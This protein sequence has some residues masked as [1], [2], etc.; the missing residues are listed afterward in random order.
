MPESEWPGRSTEEKLLSKSF[1]PT[2][3]DDILKVHFLGGGQVEAIDGGIDP[4]T[5]DNGKY[6]AKK[7]KQQPQSQQLD[8]S[9]EQMAA[10]EFVVPAYDPRIWAQAPKQNTRLARCIRSYSRNT[11]GLG[12]AVEP[13]HESKTSKTQRDDAS[14]VSRTTNK[15]ISIFSD[16]KNNPKSKGDS[17]RNGKPGQINIFSGDEETPSEGQDSENDATGE[18][19]IFTD[20]NENEKQ[21]DRDHDGIPDVVED[22]NED[23]DSER[24][25]EK[26]EIEWQAEILRELF[27]NPNDSMPLTELFYLAK[28]DEETTGNGYIEVV[29]NNVG[30]IVELHHV[31]ATTI[32]RR[33]IRAG[34]RSRG[35]VD[36]GTG[37]NSTPRQV[38]GFIQIRGNQ[39]RYFKEF[40]DRR[41]MNTQSGAWHTDEGPLGWS[42]RATEIIHFRNYDPTSQYY[43][44]PRYVPSATAIAGNR[45]AAIRNV[46]FFENDAVPRM[47]LLVS[48]GRLTS[49]SMQQIEDFV[50][51]KQRG[52]DQ[53]HR[54][55]IVQVEPTRV[56]FQQNNKT[57]IELKPLTVGVT[58]DA[59]FQ[60]YRNAN[61]EEV[62]EIFGLAPVFFSTENVNKASAAVSREITNEQEF[63]PDRLSKEYT[64]NQNIV[65]DLLCHEIRERHGIKAP[66]DEFEEREQR[67]KMRKHIL[68]Q[69]RFARM[70][71]TDPLDTAR[72]DHVYA[73]LGAMTPNELRERIDLPPYPEE[74]FFGDKPLPISMAEMSAG[75]ALLTELDEDQMPPTDLPGGMPGPGE[76]EGGGGSDK[77]QGN[78]QSP[79]I[80]PPKMP[81]MAGE[82]SVDVSGADPGSKPFAEG[83][84]VIAAPPEEKKGPQQRSTSLETRESGRGKAYPRRPRVAERGFLIA[85]N[86]MEEARRRAMKQIDGLFNLG[87]RDD[88]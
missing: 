10:G 66:E 80:D 37:P 53:A 27:N 13:L 17:R 7:K 76:E 22:R 15:A 26:K 50:R 58:E 1:D 40:G 56:G 35:S 83:I 77:P 21:P 42:S 9:F 11:V 82:P 33:M 73:S 52:A 88:N 61:D 51:G 38:Y 68:V 34:S 8:E 36:L 63:E 46:A 84:Q 5:Q 45:Q 12:W 32:R 81:G 28:V 31:P 60:T 20:P 72:M 23:G 24:E 49:E 65:T 69:F 62:R 19:N 64:I 79:D 55:M 29:R 43:G 67:R 71:L 25:R 30:R 14:T 47:A 41:V 18:I 78:L 2:D 3:G 75:L 86:M 59:S 48:G 16:E 54:V 44:A 39:K 70:T 4:G 87:G 6:P 74:Y 57:M 85:S